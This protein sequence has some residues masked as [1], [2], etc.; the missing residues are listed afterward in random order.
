VGHYDE[1][2]DKIARME[3]QLL[4]LERRAGS[5][6]TAVAPLPKELTVLPCQ[7]GDQ[8]VALADEAI[9]EVVMAARLSPLPEAPC[10][11]PGM[12]NLRG[13]AVPVIDV[14]ARTTGQARTLDLS[15]RIIIVR[16]GSGKAGLLVQQVQGVRTVQGAELLPASPTADMAPYVLGLLSGERLPRLLLS[17]KGLLRS[18]RDALEAARTRGDR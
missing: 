7:V 8:P 16:L 14:L 17:V 2:L 15:D 9:V 11:L 13:E 12:L 10:W 6:G 5:A 4:A 18:S 3:H 1:L